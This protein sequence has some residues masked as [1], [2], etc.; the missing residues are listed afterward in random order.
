MC[1]YDPVKFTYLLM[2][3]NA[4]VLLIL[5]RRVHPLPRPSR[6]VTNCSA[7]VQHD[8]CGHW[9]SKQRQQCTKLHCRRRQLLQC[10]LRAFMALNSMTVLPLVNQTDHHIPLAGLFLFLKINAKVYHGCRINSKVQIVFYCS[11]NLV[12]TI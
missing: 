1:C 12:R 7:R 8:L 3:I 9:S 11:V 2:V 10:G 4:A 5:R 6:Y